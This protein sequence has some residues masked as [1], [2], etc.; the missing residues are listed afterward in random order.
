MT[1]P[2]TWQ[3]I[4]CDQSFITSGL[5]QVDSKRI[6]L[7][8]KWCG[9]RQRFC[10]FCWSLPSVRHLINCYE[11]G[12]LMA[13]ELI[14]WL[15]LCS[16]FGSIAM[17]SKYW[18]GNGQIRRRCSPTKCCSTSTST[19][20]IRRW[21]FRCTTW[22]RDGE[23][24]ATSTTSTSSWR[25]RRRVIHFLTPIM[26]ATADSSATATSSM[27]STGFHQ[28]LNQNFVNSLAIQL[29]L[30]LQ[31]TWNSLSHRRKSFIAHNQPNNCQVQLV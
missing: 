29:G 5:F 24:A 31:I 20:L 10:R 1:S 22:R 27:D 9:T 3:Q 7:K 8:L 21:P 28:F 30:W 18:V 23:D 12:P 11:I 17:E 26:A 15:F 19:T 6:L 13:G 2:R 16:N 4:G 14:N 25:V